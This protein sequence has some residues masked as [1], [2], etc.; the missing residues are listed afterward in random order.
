MK[1]I[2]QNKS[3]FSGA[4]RSVKQS[5]SEEHIA[6]AA[7]L[8]RDQLYSDK[9]KATFCETLLNAV[10]EHRKYNVNKPVEVV[11][12]K[13]I[14]IIR[15]FANGLSPD[16]VEQVFFQFFESTKSD[17]NEAIGGFGIGAK[18]PGS[19]SDIYYVDSYHNGKKYCY[20]STVNGYEASASLLFEEECDIDN[21]G[22][23]VR[24]PIKKDTT[25]YIAFHSIIYDMIHQVGFYVDKQEILYYK[26]FD[27]NISIFSYEDWLVA[28]ANNPI[29]V[30]FSYKKLKE[31]LNYINIDGHCMVIHRYGGEPI[32]MKSSFFTSSKVWAYDGD[33]FYKI[34]LSGDQLNIFGSLYSSHILVLFFKRGELSI[35]PSREGVAMTAAT[36]AWWESKIVAIKKAINDQY[37]T[38]LTKSLEKYVPVEHA[39]SA[40][41]NI[42]GP[43]YK[44]VNA[45]YTDFNFVTS[46]FADTAVKITNGRIMSNSVSIIRPMSGMRHLFLV[47]DIDARISKPRL[48]EA[49]KTRLRQFITSSDYWNIYDSNYTPI[50]LVANDR[51]D[52]FNKIL[53]EFPY[54]RKDKDYFMVSDLIKLLPEPEKRQATPK[55]TIPNDIFT[56]RPVFDITKT[57]VIT[58]AETEANDLL[59][60]I[61]KYYSDYY[62]SSI[63]ILKFFGINN[64]ARCNAR[65]KARFLKEGARSFEELDMTKILQH[66]VDQARIVFCPEWIRDFAAKACRFEFNN[67]KNYDNTKISKQ[68]YICDRYNPYVFNTD[69]ILTD[70]EFA[71]ILFSTSSFAEKVINPT[72]ARVE[73]LFVDKIN[74]LDKN[75]SEQLYKFAYHFSNEWRADIPPK[76]EKLTAIQIGNKKESEVIQQKIHTIIRDIFTE[77]ILT[78]TK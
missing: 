58:K 10:D 69:E 30:P 61:V 34:N 63:K 50:Y 54:Y 71:T 48:V 22:I 31:A 15:D 76:F 11:L 67:L 4:T 39:V 16:K 43:L 73:K 35:L 8:V 75:T 3:V 49:L 45:P 9:R 32:E 66:S 19:Y 68:F 78:V 25:D 70:R 77:I 59:S 47:Y 13:D 12:T 29:L 56:G 33:M 2:E 26:A 65:D 7:Y 17:N 51:L 42:F 24:I 37:K 72:K 21:T 55:I 6:R 74:S 40:T 14:L 62:R 20:V 64:I 23:C 38:E 46:E 53:A 27:K 41:K 1:V 60:Y 52:K 5:I 57:L 44:L 28:K 36:N 18:A